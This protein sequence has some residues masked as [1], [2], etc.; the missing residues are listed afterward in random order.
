MAGAATAGAV[1]ELDLDRSSEG[2]VTSWGRPWPAAAWAPVFFLF[3]FLFFFFLAAADWL[4]AAAAAAAP[5]WTM[6]WEVQTVRVFTFR[7]TVSSV[8]EDE[9]KG[10]KNQ[11]GRKKEEK[12]VD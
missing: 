11:K 8:Y 9:G 10:E 5:S 7:E 6:M 3:L 4:R 1:S 12:V 2:L